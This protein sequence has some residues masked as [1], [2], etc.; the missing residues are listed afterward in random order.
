[1]ATILAVFTG[2][3]LGQQSCSQNT[4]ALFCYPAQRHQSVDNLHQ[5]DRGSY[6][7]RRQHRMLP[8]RPQQQLQQQQ[9][10]QQ[11]QHMRS[12]DGLVYPR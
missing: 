11:Q 4:T 12:N 9:Q 7:P 1:M 8:V 3:G 2:R 5:L 6:N 10:Q